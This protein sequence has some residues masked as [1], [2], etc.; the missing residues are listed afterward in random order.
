MTVRVFLKAP[1]SPVQLTAGS[2]F[3]ARAQGPALRSAGSATATL[4]PVRRTRRRRHALP[5][6]APLHDE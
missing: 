5:P 6:A 1:A 3:V 2:F 4:P